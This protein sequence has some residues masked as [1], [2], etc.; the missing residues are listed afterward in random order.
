ML[1]LET[2]WTKIKEMGAAR[3]EIC[4]ACES[5]ND[6]TR[7]CGECGCFMEA[8]TLWPGSEFPLNKWGP[9]KED[10]DTGET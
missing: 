3:M 1:K 6:F 8:K 9:Q 7:R 10:K 5:Y 4:K 2:K